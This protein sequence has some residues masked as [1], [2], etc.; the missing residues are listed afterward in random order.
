MGQPTPDNPLGLDY[1]GG[2][3][4]GA[5]TLLSPGQIT[6]KAI[7]TLGYDTSGFWGGSSDVL[8]NGSSTIPVGSG[9]QGGGFFGGMNGMQSVGAVLGGL[10]SLSNMFLGFQ[11][12]SQAK[13]Q[14]KTQ[15]AFSNANL[16]NQ[17]K[18]Y[19]TALEDRARSRA[20]VE[21][22]SASQ[23]QGYIDKNRLNFSRI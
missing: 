1:T 19:N 18:S 23:A 22:Q 5:S 9:G 16:E 3:G 12:L 15:R 4:F 14:F 7:P 2:N 10:Q 11:A 21:D 6:S 17:V 13:K 8:T 20:A